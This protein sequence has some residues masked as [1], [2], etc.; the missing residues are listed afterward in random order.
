[1]TYDEKYEAFKEKMLK[2]V[3]PSFR[4]GFEEF[5][6]RKQVCPCQREKK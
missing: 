2:D 6:K 1:M 4:A 3:T 5:L